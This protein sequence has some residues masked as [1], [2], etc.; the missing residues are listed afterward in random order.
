MKRFLFIP[1]ALAVALTGT[2]AAPFQN[3]DFEATT[4]DPDGPPSFQHISVAL[5]G[6]RA[7]FGTDEQTNVLFNTQTLGA[8]FV[9]LSG[10]SSVLQDNFSVVLVPGA[11]AEPGSA[12]L[13]QDGHIPDD[14]Q[15]LRFLGIVGGGPQ[16]TPLND[17]L[18]VFINGQQVQVTDAFS[19]PG[20]YNY[21]ADISAFAGLDAT[22]SFTSFAYSQF[23]NFLIL[24]G[25]S[26]SP[27][28]VP[29]PSTF[30]LLAITGAFGWFYWRRKRR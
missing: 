29:E 26:F 28:P 27:V 14:A 8:P 6:W 16:P 17:R 23:P 13:S 19:E 12:T 20:T 2:R 22:L 25:I 15:S 11:D 24:D 3:L 7:F 10:T 4:L 30:A 5:P 18:G 9:G 1:L 21:S